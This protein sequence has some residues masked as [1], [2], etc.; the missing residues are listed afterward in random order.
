MQPAVGR[1]DAAKPDVND[2]PQ[3]GALRQQCIRGPAPERC[4]GGWLGGLQQPK[5]GGGWN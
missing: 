3:S 4:A 2:N 5:A 1:P